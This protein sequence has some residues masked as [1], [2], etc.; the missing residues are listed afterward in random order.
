MKVTEFDHGLILSAHTAGYVRSTGLHM[1]D[2]YNSLYKGIDPK[3]YDKHDADRN[4]IPFDLNRMGVGTAFE[5]ALKPALLAQ[6]FSD[7]P[8]E[9]FTQHAESCSLYGIPVKD[10][11]ILCACGAGIAYSPDQLLWD[12]EGLILGEFKLTWYSSKNAPFEE[13]FDKWR[14]QM[15]AYC[16]HLQTLRSV[17]YPFWVNGAY[18]RGGPPAPVFEKGYRMVFEQRELDRNWRILLKHGWKKGMIPNVKAA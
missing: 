6:L 16:Y 13:K 17:L 15:M 3:R 5:E 11:L 18:P 4:E 7:R 1:S 2:I 10:G 12:D 14:C 9:F 8:G